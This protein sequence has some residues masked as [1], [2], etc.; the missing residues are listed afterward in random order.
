MESKKHYKY[1]VAQGREEEYKAEI[2][3]LKKD[4][5]LEFMQA[6]N[7]QGLHWK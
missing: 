5:M 1:M 7:A 4:K 3:R 2:V 6:L